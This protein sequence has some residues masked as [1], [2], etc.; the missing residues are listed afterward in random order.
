MFD[1]FLSLKKMCLSNFSSKT[2]FFFLQYLLQLGTVSVLKEKH[3]VKCITESWT[4]NTQ[5]LGNLTRNLIAS[6]A[7]DV[8][9]DTSLP[10]AL[11]AV[12]NLQKTLKG[13]FDTEQSGNR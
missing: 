6:D 13:S 5:I 4:K 7:H 11:A 9:I 10:L 1:V 8:Q 3:K 2:I 12:H